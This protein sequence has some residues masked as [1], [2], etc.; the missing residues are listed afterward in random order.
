MVPAVGLQA[1]AEAAALAELLHL[2]HLS[3]G[4]LVTPAPVQPLPLPTNQTHHDLIAR[5][6]D[7]LPLFRQ[8]LLL[9]VGQLG[10]SDSRTG[11]WN[12]NAETPVTNGPRAGLLTLGAASRPTGWLSLFLTD[13]HTNPQPP[14][15][16]VWGQLIRGR[17]A[18]ASFALIG[19]QLFTC[20]GGEQGGDVRKAGDGSKMPR[21][22]SPEG[23]GR[24]ITV[25]LV[26]WSSTGP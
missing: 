22:G 13:S 18:I 16:L 8:L 20:G 23:L 7:L 6:E 2:S 4:A 3:E 26:P 15:V 14:T 1:D 24:N 19:R 17:P 10:P 11:V 25:S 21:A 9:Q 5:P 12:V